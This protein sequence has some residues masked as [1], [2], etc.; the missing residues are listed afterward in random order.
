MAIALIMAGGK[1]ER[2]WPLSRSER[3][4]QFS[5]L[6]NRTFFQ[7]TVERITPFVGQ[8]GVYAVAQAQHC[9]EILREI[10]FLG[11]EHLIV[12]PIG[13]NTAPSIGLSALHIARRNPEEIMIVLPA[14][15]LIQKEDHF[16]DLL[17]WGCELAQ[18]D[19]LVTLGIRPS[20][21]HTGYGYIHCGDPCEQSN[22]IPAYRVLQ[23]TEKP[24]T[25]TAKR[26]CAEGTYFWNSGIFLWKAQVILEEMEK[27]LPQLFA[28]LSEIKKHI[29]KPDEQAITR[30]VFQNLDALSIDYGVMEKS[31]R[32]VMIPADIGWND[33]GSWEALGDIFQKD[34][35]QNAF[36][37][38]YL[39]ID[40]Q[41]CIICNQK[42]VITYGVDD[43]VIVERD[44]IILVLPKKR[45][46]EVKR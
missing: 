10:P 19:Y 27:Y 44:D 4:K 38:K 46:Q 12:E 2:L 15:H 37:G 36:S 16:R 9:S 40:S 17:F 25:E 14:D 20:T 18:M 6:F 30:D 21:P 13:K 11:R 31:K 45:S 35:F 32:V 7:M 8:N 33:M 28:G 22:Q 3:P 26:Y 29:G 42:P 23:F 1:G 39:G 24:D 43:L 5:S 41:G 34:D